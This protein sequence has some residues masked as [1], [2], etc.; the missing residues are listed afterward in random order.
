MNIKEIE[1]KLVQLDGSTRLPAVDGSLLTNINGSNVT[2][3]IKLQ[4]S[5]QSGASFYVSSASV[6]GQ[7]V[8]ARTSGNVGVGTASPSAKLA[9]IG[10][11]TGQALLGDPGLLQRMRA[12]G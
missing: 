12:G 6:D 2:N 4:E 11:G 3:V 5:L 8:L 1:N 9:I 7:T 10:A